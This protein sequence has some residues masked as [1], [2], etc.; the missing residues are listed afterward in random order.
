MK[1]NTSQ[2][3]QAMI[4]IDEAINALKAQH[5][6]RIDEAATKILCHVYDWL[7]ATAQMLDDMDEVEQIGEQQRG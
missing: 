5:N 1:P 6:R 3:R 4:Y 7:D 2:M